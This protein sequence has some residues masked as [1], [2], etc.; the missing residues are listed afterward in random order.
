MTEYGLFSDEGCVERD[1]W[2][3]EEALERLNE[4]SPEDELHVGIVC[5]DCEGEH[6]WCIEEHPRDTGGMPWWSR[7]S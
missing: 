2:S 7:S 5:Q 3:Q 4:Y 6:P 1:S